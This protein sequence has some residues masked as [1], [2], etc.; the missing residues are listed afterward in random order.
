VVLPIQEK[1]ELIKD[2]EK[3]TSKKQISFQYEIK[4][5][6]IRDIFEHKDKLMKFTSTS[7][8]RSSIIKE[9]P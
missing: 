9:K 3:G 6:T 8:N 4:E 1:L 5:S 2:I 7:D